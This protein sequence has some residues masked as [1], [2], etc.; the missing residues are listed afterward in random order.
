MLISAVV[1]LGIALL[2]KSVRSV[3]ASSVMLAAMVDHV[4]TELLSPLLW[5]SL[6]CVTG[7]GLGAGL[8][9]TGMQAGEV[10][11]RASGEAALKRGLSVAC[12]VAYPMMALL[13][14]QHA[15]VPGARVVG[16]HGT[17]TSSVPVTALAVTLLAVILGAFSVQAVTH[18]RPAQAV[19]AGAMSAM[20]VAMLI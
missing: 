5:A 9:Q 15:A 20:L 3:A 17:A 10:A 12:A 1:C 14:V 18:R 7:I 8:R 11:G 19:E 4:L 13:V 16:H 6:L 2:S